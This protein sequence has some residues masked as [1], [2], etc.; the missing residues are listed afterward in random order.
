MNFSAK[1]IKSFL[2]NLYKKYGVLNYNVVVD[3]LAESSM[4][5]IDSHGIRLASH[6]LKEMSAG[7]INNKPK[8]RFTK[9]GSAS[10]LMDADHG[11]GIYAGITAMEK[12]INVANKTGIA[13]VAVKNGTHF[14]AA[15]IYS[16]LAAKQGMIG[17]AF[18]NSESYVVPFG[19]KK[20]VLGTNP[21]SF[22][23]PGDFCLDIATSSVAWNKVLVYRQQGKELDKEWA[24]D[25][26][27]DTTTDAKSARYLRHFGSHKGYGLAMMVEILCTLLT[28]SPFGYELCPMYPV[29]G[30]KR[31]IG[32]YFIAIKIGNISLFKKKFA[33]MRRMIAKQPGVIISG[34]DRVKEYK[35]RSAEGIEVP[36]ELIEDFNILAEKVNLKER[37]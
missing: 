28:G 4:R 24:V 11:F 6:Y 9:N 32:Y 22:A 37:L 33:E 21:I 26:N 35:R 36:N 16:R 1:T 30:D 13:C 27:G 31:K 20:V 34:D 23:A 10:L 2:G 8:F 3:S 25:E 19:G 12:A 29:N 17:I 14:G 5:G 7:R 15:E 18:C